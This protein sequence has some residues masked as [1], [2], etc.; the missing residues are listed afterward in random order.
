MIGVAGG[1][2]TLPAIEIPWW[3]I[4]SGEWQVARL[5]ERELTILPSAEALPPV[6]PPEPE[7]EAVQDESVD[8]TAEYGLP[9][10]FWRRVSEL[11]AGLWVVTLVAW[12]WTSRPTRRGP[13]EP[14]PV[15]V[16]KRQSRLLRDARKAARAG[17][18]PGVKDALLE[19]AALE[20]PEDPPRSVGALAHRVS[21]DLAG[22]LQLFSR[23][24]YGPEPGRFDGDALAAAI[25]SFSVRKDD[26]DG[27]HEALP[28]LLPGN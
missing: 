12:W 24:S 23:Q 13:A 19:W 8:D 26:D 17:D 14:A 7:S 2:V 18:G 6:P 15:P 21:D 11:L 1:T 25:R 28:P 22:Q 20:W 16:H 9:A 5:P 27:K 10:P 3:D 4:E